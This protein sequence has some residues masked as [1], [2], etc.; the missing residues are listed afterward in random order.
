CPS[1]LPGPA[2]YDQL[3]WPL[4]HLRIEVVQEHAKGRLRRPGARVQLRPPRRPDAGEITAKVIDHDV[5]R[6]GG[7]HVSAPH[8]A[9]TAAMSEPSQIDSPTPSLSPA[10]GPAAPRRCARH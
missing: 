3:L 1:P 6:T 7:A 5:E 9:S 10:S 4:G 8:S 2:V